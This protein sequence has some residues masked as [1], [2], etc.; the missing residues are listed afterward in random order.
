[1]SKPGKLEHFDS[2]PMTID[3][4]KEKIRIDIEGFIDNLH[5]LE[6]Y[7]DKK[8]TMFEWYY[9]FGSWN[10]A[11]EFLGEDKFKDFWPDELK[12]TTQEI[13]NVSFSVK[14]K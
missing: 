3:R 14:D 10:E 11:L 7:K 1:M 12:N 6:Y 13:K 9:I 8:F 4:W 5:N 2:R